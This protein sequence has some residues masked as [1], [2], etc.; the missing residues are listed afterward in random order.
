[1]QSCPNNVWTRLFHI[2]DPTAFTNINNGL[3]V[4]LRIPSGSLAAGSQFI[5]LGQFDLRPGN[6]LMEYYPPSAYLEFLQCQEYLQVL[7]T[8]ASLEPF[9]T[10]SWYSTTQAAVV[11]PLLA[12]MRTL[13]SLTISTSADFSLVTAAGGSVALT[14]GPT[15]SGVGP[16]GFWGLTTVASGGV[17]GNGTELLGSPTNSARMYLAAEF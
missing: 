12:Q 8:G 7:G 1:L 3:E 11:V 10:G 13:P 14:A 15:L 2:F 4:V 9:G 5:L 16:R 6:H 17:A